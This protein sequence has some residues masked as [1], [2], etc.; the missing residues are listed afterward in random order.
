MKRL[1]IYSGSF[2][3]VHAGHIAFAQA[4]MITC[5]LDTVV[6]MPE[7]LPRWK[8]NISPLTSR[9]S[10]LRDTLAHTPFTILE[11]D[12]D[13]F[14]VETTLPELQ[15]HYPDYELVFLVGSDVALHSLPRWHSLE[16]LT[17]HYEFAVGMRTTETNRQVQS[18]M[19]NLQARYV[20]IETDQASLS[21][22]AFR[23]LG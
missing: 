18:V 4:A 5:Q 19:K 13:R 22:T 23:N 15:V 12:E 2:D 17:Q 10:K 14:T 11:L 16:T 7:R 6:F 20:L 21:S 3:P 1:G 9:L 8:P